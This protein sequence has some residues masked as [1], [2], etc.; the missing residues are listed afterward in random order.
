MKTFDIDM[1]GSMRYCGDAGDW[2]RVEVARELY[3]KLKYS[4][5]ILQGIL[6]DPGVINVFKCHYDHQ[7][8]YEM[9]KAIENAEEED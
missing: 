4:V 3:E 9:I 6:E 2:V 8:V 1:D 5:D 7:D